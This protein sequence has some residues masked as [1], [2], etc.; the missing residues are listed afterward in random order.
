MVEDMNWYL[1]KTGQEYKA[2]EDWN[3]PEEARR[4]LRAK[5]GA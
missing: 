4:I 2:N 5:A 1:P 3:F